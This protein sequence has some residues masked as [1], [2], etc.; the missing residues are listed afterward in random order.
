MVRNCLLFAYRSLRNTERLVN[1]SLQS[2]YEILLRDVANA[3]SPNKKLD[4]NIPNSEVE[5]FY[6]RRL[7]ETDFMSNVQSKILSKVPASG[8]G[9]VVSTGTNFPSGATVVNS[10]NQFSL[11]F[12][13][14]WELVAQQNSAVCNKLPKHS[15]KQLWEVFLK[16]DTGTFGMVERDGEGGSMGRTWWGG[17]GR[18]DVR[19]GK[20]QGH[21]GRGWD[22]WEVTYR[23]G[24]VCGGEVGDAWG[25]VNAF[26]VGEGQRVGQEGG[27]GI[28]RR[29][30][31]R[32]ERGR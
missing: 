1:E 5:A 32:R 23:V 10:F 21:G 22:A 4:M 26:E 20:G 25:L 31:E 30:G 7:S 11:L 8:P 16:L 2:P 12:S 18:V 9:M 24:G 14:V 19:G 15:G 13:V 3:L 29:E 28:W 27:G 6:N 17:V